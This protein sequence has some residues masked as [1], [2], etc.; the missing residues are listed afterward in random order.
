MKMLAALSTA[1]IVAAG[2]ASACPMSG[3][4]S[5]AVDRDTVVASIATPSQTPI[6]ADERAAPI[7]A[8]EKDAE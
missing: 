7:V 2:T 4:Q 6:P 8:G 5:A 3:G 1:L